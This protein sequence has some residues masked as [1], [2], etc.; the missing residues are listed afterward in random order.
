MG[1]KP[2]GGAGTGKLDPEAVP[3]DLRAVSLAAAARASDVATFDL[4]EKHLRATQDAQLRTELLEALGGM[5]APALAERARALIL[6]KGLLRRNELAPLLMPQMEDEKARPALRQWVDTHFKT[7]EA[8]LAP[9]GARLVSVYGAGM[10][11][12]QDAAD[13]LSRFGERMKTVEGGPR[14]LKQEAENI[15][16][17]AELRDAQRAKGFGRAL[18]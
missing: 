1:Q 11:S 5:T 15:G 14:A 3:R 17:C 8:S 16:L 18:Q 4:L 7:L 10:C 13:L 2:D 12:K 9:A 6:E